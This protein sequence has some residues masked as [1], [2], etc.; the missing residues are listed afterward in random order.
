[1]AVGEKLFKDKGHMEFKDKSISVVIPAY[2][3]AKYIERAVKETSNFLWKNFGSFEIIVV[4]DGSTDETLNILRGLSDKVP[5]LK[6]LYN[7]K[8]MGKGYS[9]RSGVLAASGKYIMFTDTDFSVPINEIGKFINKID[10]GTDIV[11]GS[12]AI[13]GANIIKGQNVIRKNMGRTFNLLIRVLLFDGIRD[14]QCGFKVFKNS[15]ARRIFNISRINGFSFD[16]EI[17]YI[18]KKLGYS[19]KEIPVKWENRTDSRVSMIRSSTR[20]FFD[21]FAIRRNNTKGFYGS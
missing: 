5:G 13:K 11:I 4:D 1:M 12:R 2:N 20:M 14:T 3:E 19:V 15:V 18:A 8:N 9:A 17:L 6:V 21:I 7:G 16:A 10:E